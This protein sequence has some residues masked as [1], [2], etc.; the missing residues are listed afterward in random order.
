[1]CNA[2]TA[3]KQ[4]QEAAPAEAVSKEA[5]AAE[6]FFVG[7]VKSYNGRRGFGFLTCEETARDFGRDVYLSKAE[8]QALEA[9]G[10][11]ALAEADL[12]RF[13]VKLSV[14]GFPQAVCAERFKGG[15]AV[16]TAPPTL[17]LTTV[18]PAERCWATISEDADVETETPVALAGSGVS[19]STAKPKKTKRTGSKDK[20]PQ[21]AKALRWAP[22]DDLVSSVSFFPESA[23]DLE[24]RP[25]AAVPEPG[26]PVITQVLATSPSAVPAASV[27]LEALPAGPSMHHMGW[28]CI[29]GGLVPPTLAPELR[30]VESVDKT[31]SLCVCWPSVVHAAAYKVRVQELRQGDGQGNAFECGVQGG[32][33]VALVELCLQG[34]VPGMSY[35]VSVRCI[36]PC[37]CESADSDWACLMPAPLQQAAVQ[38]PMMACG[39]CQ[40]SPATDLGLCERL[41]LA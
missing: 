40:P 34:L 36:A 11:A 37:G 15:V 5:V 12:V 9:D 22:P 18:E 13:A 14:E 20:A 30:P 25:D 38:A 2:G 39:P 19:A 16:P 17:S 3:G 33:P 6:K 32:T 4:A 23:S 27:M 28:R 8:V 26:T 41:L 7:A 1:M 29:H 35:A 31:M 10:G 24:I 21:P